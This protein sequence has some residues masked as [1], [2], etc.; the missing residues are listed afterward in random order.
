MIKYKTLTVNRFL[1]VDQRFASTK[2]FPCVFD[3][4]EVSELAIILTV[5]NDDV[6]DFS[7]FE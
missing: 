2:N 5:V 7:W 3:A 4:E 1:F 6:C